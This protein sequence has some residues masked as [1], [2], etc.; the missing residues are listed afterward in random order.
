MVLFD[1]GATHSF[2]SLAFSAYANISA[3]PLDLCMTIM[4]PMG[5]SMLVNRVY[6]SCLISVGGMDFLVDLLPLKMHDFDVILGMDW[7]ASYY[8]SIDCF[9]KEIVFHKLREKEFRFRGYETLVTF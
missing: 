5:D 6:K 8:A 3:K 2:V 4:T 7:L 9:S 1:S